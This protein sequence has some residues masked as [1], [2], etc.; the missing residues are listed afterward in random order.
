MM[1]VPFLPSIGNHDI[2]TQ[3]GA[4]YLNNWTLP[5]NGP[6]GIDPERCYSIR[7]GDVHLVSLDLTPDPQILKEVILPW[8]RAD[9]A[10]ADTRWRFVFAHYPIYT[11]GAVG[12]PED[13]FLVDLWS[14]IF[15]ELGVDLY[16]CGHNHFYERSH[17][18]R[19]G[20]TVAPGEGTVYLI[21]GAGGRSLYELAPP[22][23]YS[24]AAIDTS[25]GFTRVIVE[26]NRIEISF[27]DQLGDVLD[28]TAWTKNT[29]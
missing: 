7:V 29:N 20:Q 1:R 18:L 4:P 24:A 10:S 21:S 15:D 17:P 27:I 16:L 26:G 2:G 6:D 19:G 22:A 13:Q 23:P 14:P 28:Q 11:S 3:D 9:L 5:R 25:F 8:A 12:R